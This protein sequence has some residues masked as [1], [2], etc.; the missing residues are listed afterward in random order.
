MEIGARNLSVGYGGVPVLAGIDLT[1]RPGQLVGLIGPNGSGKTTLLRALAGLA[2]PLGGSILYD[3]G[4]LPPR[5]LAR[6]LAY[7]AQGGEVNWALS[8][9][10]L[11][12]LGRLPHRSAFAGPGDADRDAVA[13]AL[14]LADAAHLR[15]RTVATLSGGERA[16]VLLARALAVESETLLADEPVATLDPL[17]QLA[18]LALL[19]EGAGRGLGVVVVLHDLA[20]AFRFCDRLILV[21]GGRI[22]GDGPPA[23]VLTDAVLA[24]AYRVRA[25]RASFE[26]EPILLPWRPVEPGRAGAPDHDER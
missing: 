7:L 3:G 5:A 1:L 4:R 8:V 25:A 16:R 21:A 24:G 15:G 6:R 20:L 17:H 2:P 18:T 19:R 14:A 13:R 9:E 11:V 12:E 22:V 23:A 26:G 10:N